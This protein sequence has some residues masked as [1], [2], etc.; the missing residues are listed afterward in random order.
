MQTTLTIMQAAAV[1][2]VSMTEVNRL[3]RKRR[4]A[5]HHRSANKVKHV[6][7]E[8]L[9]AYITRMNAERALSE[10]GHGCC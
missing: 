4:L 10:A 3:I 7:V 5:V 8:S 1:L 2:G 6:A 9:Q